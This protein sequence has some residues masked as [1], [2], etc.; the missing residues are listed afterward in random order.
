MR[1]R[2]VAILLVIL[3]L[4]VLAFALGPRVPVDTTVTFDAN[5]IGRDPEG[6]LA[7]REAE[8]QDIRPGLEKEV[9]RADPA[10][11]AKTPLAIVYVHG[12]SASKG[13]VRPLPGNIAAALHANLFYTRLTGHGEDGAAMAKGS[14]NAW[15]ND[16]A[17][18]IAIG[19][20]IGERVVVIGTS[21][22]GSLATWAATQPALSADVAAIVMISPNYGLQAAGSS[23]LTLPWGGELAEF[24]V[25][26][27]RSFKPVNALNAALWT[28]RYPTRALLP[29]AGLTKLAAEAP[30]EKV[31][32]PA[33]FVFSDQDKVVR[34]DLTR[35]I[36]A[37]WGA[38]HE[39]VVVE[40][41]DDPSD[42][43]LAGDALSPS[44]TEE[45]TERIVVWI[46]KTVY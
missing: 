4:L 18:A 21:T 30:V 33:L 7:R 24:L 17:E 43:V 34:P 2:A 45:L 37:R 20:A 39:L 16:Y 5:V 12:F 27:E 41:S 3:A 25:G 29:L 23:L 40:R 31:R 36:A 28:T 42:H 14:V 15:V 44:T 13:E 11:K 10:T 35:A 32:T 9:V 38:P 6:Y 19:R 46:R 26:K 1:K 8:V 22:G